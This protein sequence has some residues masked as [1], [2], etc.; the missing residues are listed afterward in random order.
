M[1]SF[2]LRRLLSAV[3]TL[4]VLVTLTFFLMRAAPGGPFDGERTLPPQVEAALTREYHLDAP[5]WR[6]Y[7]DYLG[8]LAH[9]DLGPSFQYEGY[10]VTELIGDAL[11]VSL[12]LGSAAL[13][14]SLL[15]GGVIGAVAALRQGRWIDPLLTHITLIGVS[16]PNY[17]I[18]PLLVLL[19]A[20]TLGWLPA[21]GWHHDRP[22]DMVL[23][24]IALALPQIAYIARLLRNGLIDALAT[25]YL[26]TARAKGLPLRLLVLRHAWRPAV[27]PVISHLGPAAAG[28]LTG[29]VVVEQVFGIPGL[30]R[31]FVQAAL[32]RDYT[33]VLGAVL[34][35]GTL[36]VLFN[37]VVDLLYGALDPR[38][39]TA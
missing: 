29:S 36:I 4:F 20:V 22:T 31:Y 9:G 21:G 15:L 30:G 18:A 32:N 10:R 1:L 38:L 39:R 17:V 14:L 33:L 8:N 5:L 3:P 11:P 16:I 19:F 13:A 25:P 34:L 37:F 27:L 24:V 26:R 23:P 2:A 28:L 35:Y 12:A 6:Q 7:L